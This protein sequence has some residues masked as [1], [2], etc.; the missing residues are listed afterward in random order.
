MQLSYPK[1]KYM[2]L[3][4]PKLSWQFQPSAGPQSS[5]TM[6]RFF[7]VQRANFLGPWTRGLPKDLLVGGF[8]ASTLKNRFGIGGHYSK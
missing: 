4:Y 2:Q 1:M 7:A 6:L 3:S 8:I 5:F